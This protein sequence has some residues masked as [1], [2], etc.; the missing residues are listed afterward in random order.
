MKH[1]LTVPE[2]I[3]LSLFIGFLLVAVSGATSRAYDTPFDS[4]Q[5]TLGVAKDD[6]IS[7]AFHIRGAKRVGIHVPILTSG[8]INLRGGYDVDSTFTFVWHTSDESLFEIAAGTGEISL[9]ITELV[10]GFDYFQ[11]WLGIAQGALRTFHVSTK[12]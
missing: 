4:A 2:G 1:K 10:T 11:I 9:D 6:S 7:R 3:I 8:T 12:W 5:D